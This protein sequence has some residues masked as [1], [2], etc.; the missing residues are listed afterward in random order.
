[1]AMLILP[2]V[3]EKTWGISADNFWPKAI[4]SVHDR[5]PGFMFLAEVYWNLEGRLQKEGFDYTYDRSFYHHLGDRKARR[6]R[7]HL[8]AEPGIQD[9]MAR[10]LE[11][12]DEFRAAAVFPPQIHGPA[13]ILA[14]LAPGLRIFHQGQFEGRRIRIPVQLRRRPAEPVDHNIAGFYQRLLRCIKDPVFREGDW[15]LLECRP[16]WEDNP[17]YDFFVAYAWTLKD[18]QKHLIAVNYSDTQS[19]CYVRIGWTDLAGKS[20]RLRDRMGCAIYERNGDELVEKGLFLDMPAWAYH[21]FEVTAY[22]FR[23]H[24]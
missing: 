6:I 15:Q 5:N 20:W 13:A 19:Q 24:P 10:F 9:K 1:V 3:F 18:G 14:F 11:N 12:H 7:E 17:T 21:V 22:A 16:A 8:S 4:K 2:E 23:E